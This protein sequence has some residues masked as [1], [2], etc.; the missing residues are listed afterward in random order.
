MTTP[1]RPSFRSAL[2][3]LETRCGGEQLLA[4][5]LHVKPRMVATYHAGHARPGWSTCHYLG[6]VSGVLYGAS[7]ERASAT[8]W[9]EAP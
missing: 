2:R 5:L 3:D 8:W 7:D 1:D 6:R 4:S 9:R